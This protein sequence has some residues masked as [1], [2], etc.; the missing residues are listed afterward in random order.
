[1]YQGNE[2]VRRLLKVSTI[3]VIDLVIDLTT[4]KVSTLVLLTGKVVKVGAPWPI[5]NRNLH[6]EEV[7]AKLRCIENSADRLR[8][9]LCEWTG[10]ANSDNELF[11]LDTS[12]LTGAYD[13]HA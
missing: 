6:G 4:E 9:K 10:I 8:A 12:Q 1:M 11:R 7:V 2:V 13:S 5:G 3:V